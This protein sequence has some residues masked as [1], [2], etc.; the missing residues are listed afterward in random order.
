MA[1]PDRKSLLSPSFR[2]MPESSEVGRPLDS[3]IR[4]NDGSSEQKESEEQ[5]E[6]KNKRKNKRGLIPFK[7]QP[8]AAWNGIPADDVR[9][10]TVGVTSSS[11]ET[12]A[13]SAYRV[14]F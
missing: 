10:I 12:I 14:N 9:L 5:K 2:R 7:T 6:V 8:G 3:G 11:N 4:R 13:V 1:A